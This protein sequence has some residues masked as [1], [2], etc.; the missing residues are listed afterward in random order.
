MEG[1]KEKETKVLT[2]EEFDKIISSQGYNSVVKECIIK[3]ISISGNNFFMKHNVTFDSCVIESISIDPIIRKFLSSLIIFSKCIIID[4]E[5]VEG[6]DSCGLIDCTLIK[7]VSFACPTEGEFIGYKK[8]WY[9]S[10][11]SLSCSFF[12]VKL[13]IPADAKRSSGFSNKCR[14]DKAK[15]LGIYDPDG[16]DANDITEVISDFNHDFTY[17]IGG[18]VYPDSFDDNR[19]NECS[20]GIHFFMTF[21]EAR[22]Y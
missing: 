16:N 1:M 20:N 3:D 10:G 5:K 22:D 21:K 7:P 8:C 6:I 17:R 18:W 15:V 2:Q 9:R 13:L 12:I 14:C 19:F 11:N 4:Y